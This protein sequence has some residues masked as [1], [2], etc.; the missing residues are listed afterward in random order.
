[1][2]NNNVLWPEG[3]K[4]T[5]MI[6]INLDAELFWIQVDPTVIDKPK[7]RS[8]GQYGMT[9]GLPRVLDVLDRYGIKATF[10]VP[11]KIAEWYPEDLKSI[12]EK[13]H[14]IACRGYELTNMALL[15]PEEQRDVIE[16]GIHALESCTGEKI[17]G[18][19]APEG[20]VTMDTLRIA[21]ELGL[22]Y[23][24]T[25]M[26]DDRPYWNVLENEKK[27]LEIPIHWVMYDLPYFAFNYHPA[28][29]IGQGR[30]ANYKGVVNN[31]IDEF[32]GYHERGLC[33]VLQIDP[34]TIGNPGKIGML[35]EICEKILS[36]GDVWIP[37]C[38]EL[39]EYF[40]V[41]KN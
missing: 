21:K 41:A 13:G 35:E 36:K 10:F 28:F 12:V 38:K 24:S 37:T 26:D 17:I 8:M 1:M 3:K 5:A 20:E 22:E 7:A 27:Q 16:K 6:T 25:L 2:S 29:P 32:E 4:C 30:M 11:G 18:F 9:N 14:E 40:L 15:E 33:Y 19:R 31:W 34:Q 23:S 39:Y